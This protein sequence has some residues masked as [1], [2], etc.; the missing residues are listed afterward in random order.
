[1]AWVWLVTWIS[2][3]FCGSPGTSAGP[4][5]PPFR[6]ASRESSRSPPL[7]APVWQV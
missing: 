1:M 2:R 7:C 3:L 4:D 5:F 6:M